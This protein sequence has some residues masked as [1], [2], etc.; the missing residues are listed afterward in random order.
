MRIHVS[1]VN[2]RSVQLVQRC[3]IAQDIPVL[4]D[5]TFRFEPGN[6]THLK[7]DREPEARRAVSV[8]GRMKVGQ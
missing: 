5:L 7:Y 1:S 3:E 8:N 2:H 4:V 6:R